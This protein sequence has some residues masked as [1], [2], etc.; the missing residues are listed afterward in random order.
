MIH[1]GKKLRLGPRKL[2]SLS[3]YAGE[4]INPE[5]VDKYNADGDHIKRITRRSP[6]EERLLVV[7]VGEMNISL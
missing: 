1:H 2:D 7:I 5:T 3:T 6:T 4:Q